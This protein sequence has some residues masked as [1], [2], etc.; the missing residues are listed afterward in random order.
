MIPNLDSKI[1][2]TNHGDAVPAGGRHRVTYPDTSDLWPALIRL[3]TFMD[4]RVCSI[5]PQRV[6]VAER[7]AAVD[8]VA[9]PLGA[10]PAGRRS[11]SHG[12]RL[13][14]NLCDD[15][16]PGG[17]AGFVCIVRQNVSH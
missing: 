10:I 13:V 6:S 4:N 3:D 5:W 12:R 8:A 2:V 9:A 1:K 15:G 7:R 11:N 16:Y 17:D 14:K